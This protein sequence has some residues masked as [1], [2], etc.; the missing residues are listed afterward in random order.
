MGL[1]EF[2]EASVVKNIPTSVAEYP[3]RESR[4][5]QIQGASGGFTQFND[6]GTGVYIPCGKTTKSVA[7][8]IYT[9]EPVER[10]NTFAFI[11]QPLNTDDVLEFPNSPTESIFQELQKFWDSSDL[12]S[13][14]GFLHSRGI[15]LYG[16]AGSGKSMIV[17]R[18]LS[19][20]VGSN[21]IVIVVTNPGLAVAGLGHFRQIEPNRNIVLLFEDVDAIIARWGEP[22]ILS[23]LDG[24]SKINHVLS[25]AT[26]NYPEKL[27][28][29]L[30]ARP[31]RFDRVIKVNM[32][33]D[34]VRRVYFTKKLKIDES[35]LEMWVA[36]TK[37]FS[38]A[39]LAELVISVKCLDVDFSQVQQLGFPK[40]EIKNDK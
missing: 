34:A 33:D 23:L 28:R 26:T 30:V 32:P 4:G 19:D 25:L 40:M 2:G 39:A 11:Q 10:L 9:I 24:E 20:V 22:D 14:Y 12:Y 3:P 38:F 37:G 27:D 8:G 35:E 15:L 5:P 18:V 36:N 13:H 21:G 1:E 16:P 7:A 6:V 29:R 17:K 31:R